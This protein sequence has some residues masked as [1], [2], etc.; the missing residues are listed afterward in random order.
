MNSVKNMCCC[1]CSLRCFIRAILFL[2]AI[3][4]MGVGFYFFYRINEH[5]STEDRFGLSRDESMF[6]FLPLIVVMVLNF[7]VSFLFAFNLGVPFDFFM[8][9]ELFGLFGSATAGLVLLAVAVHNDDLDKYY[10]D[11]I[12]WTSFWVFWALHLYA[13]RI[14]NSIRNINTNDDDVEAA[15]EGEND[16]T[17]V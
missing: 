9:R 5:T 4:D 3:F 17:A 6:I 14:Y 12:V 11:F 1:C 15:N 16:E 8:K 10:I 7:K 2:R 13:I